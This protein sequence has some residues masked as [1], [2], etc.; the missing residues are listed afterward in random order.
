MVNQDYDSIN[1]TTEKRHRQLLEALDR[2]GRAEDFENIVKLLSPPPDIFQFAPLRA[3]TNVKIGIIGAG[4]A[5]LCAAHE[6]RKLGAEIAIY[7]AEKERIGG[8]V[9]TYYFDRSKQYYGEFGSSCIPVSH[10]T[11]WHYIDLFQLNTESLP[12][13]RYNNFIYANGA[14][15]R[16]DQTGE[17]ITDQLYPY[18]ELTEK[19]R[20]T[21]W[22]KIAHFA[23]N[24]MLNGLSPQ[25]RTEILQIL[26]EYSEEYAAI[27]RL[28]NRRVFEL[29]GLSQGA[30][31]L[32]SAVDPFIGSILNVSHDK[33][34]SSS[35]SLDFMNQYCIREGMVQ[36]PYAFYDSLMSDDPLEFE[37]PSYFLGKVDFRFGQAVTGIS[38]N[39]HTGQ[40]DL[41]SR[42]PKGAESSEGFDYVIC[43]IPFSTLREVS[44]S[45]FFSNRKLQAIK[46][47][48]YIDAQKTISLCKKRFWEED[49]DSGNM[50]GGISVTDLPIQSILYPPDHITC[51]DQEESCSSDVPGVLVMS[52]NL[53]QDSLRVSNQAVNRYYQLIKHN[54]EEV[55][56]LPEDYLD[57]IIQSHQTVHWSSEHWSR[58]AFYMGYP[59][60]K[61]NFAYSVQQP[62]YHGKV[63]FAGEHTSTKPGWI[64]GALSSGKSAANQVAMRAAQTK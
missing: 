21:P 52:S 5:G 57:S 26:P 35:Y 32:L 10:E 20:N 1:P 13:L 25:L 34:L 42:N 2:N 46:E 48:N 51:S 36:L 18:Y 40:V 16:Q 38:E 53:G 24:T 11:A 45:P 54:V 22:N 59:G 60:Q 39:L 9:F 58:G 23:A 28:S 43:A 31:D 50:N 56:G 14:R 55:H 49:T 41:R 62:E 8:R 12:S 6:L 63:F 4:L 15:L 33:L 44:M 7:D 47:L 27:T 64:Q 19:E 37:P 29:L 30:I 17:N 3:L 61:M